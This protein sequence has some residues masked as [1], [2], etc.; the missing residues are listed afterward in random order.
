MLNTTFM[1]EF[2]YLKREVIRLSGPLREPNNQVLYC[3]YHYSKFPLID[4]QRNVL[5]RFEQFCIPMDLNGKTVVDIGANL[6]SMAFEAVRRGANHA[7]CLEYNSER[8]ALGNRL[9]KFLDVPVK[10][11]QADLNTNNPVAGQQFDIVFCCALDQHLKDRFIAYNLASDMC[12][13]DLY[14]ESNLYDWEVDKYI[15]HFCKP[16][17]FNGGVYLGKNTD[18]K[19]CDIRRLFFF[20]KK[21]FTAEES[22]SI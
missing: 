16:G 22:A 11:Y 1:S 2:E 13:G 7:V 19:Y 4:G 20:T 9:A 3:T 6:G 5:K 18:D 21:K 8:V 14:L 15:A 10:F 17:S 12:R